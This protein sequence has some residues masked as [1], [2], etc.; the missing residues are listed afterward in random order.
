[1]MSSIL[2]GIVLA[3][4][5]LSIAISLI[6]NPERLLTKLRR[7]LTQKHLRATRLIG[8]MFLLGVLLMIVQLLRRFV[9]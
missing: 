6:K 2:P 8:A 4:V 1:M 7:P 3:A 9:A 5:M